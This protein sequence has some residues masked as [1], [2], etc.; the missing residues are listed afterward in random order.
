MDQ[1]TTDVPSWKEQCTGKLLS[2]HLR[3]PT[4]AGVWVPFRFETSTCFSADAANA[5]EIEILVH[6]THTDSGSIVASDFCGRGHGPPN[7]PDNLCCFDWNL[8]C[9]AMTAGRS[10]EGKK[11]CFLQPLLGKRASGRVDFPV[12]HHDLALR[13]LHRIESESCR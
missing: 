1:V 12:I 10:P 11:H 5:H 6:G 7:S 4:L 8:S 13:A 9:L 2:L 3:H